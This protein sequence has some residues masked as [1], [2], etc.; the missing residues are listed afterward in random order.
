MVYIRLR[1]ATEDIRVL[2]WEKRDFEI[3]KGRFIRM[4]SKWCHSYWGDVFGQIKHDGARGIGYAA[5]E[6]CSVYYGRKRS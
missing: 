1:R 3:V 5:A 6:G 4:W 2:T